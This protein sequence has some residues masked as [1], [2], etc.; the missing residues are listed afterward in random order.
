MLYFWLPCVLRDSE[1]IEG[2]IFIAAKFPGKIHGCE[3]RDPA[4]RNVHCYRI[5]PKWNEHHVFL[6]S[7]IST[8]L[9][10]K[11]LTLTMNDS[12]KLNLKSTGKFLLRRRGQRSKVSESVLVE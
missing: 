12:L 4:S 10:G 8:I 2:V 9:F 1:V 6:M 3:N 5:K 11:K 7:S